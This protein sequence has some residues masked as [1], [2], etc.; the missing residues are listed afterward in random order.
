MAG[1][2]AV[3]AAL[4]EDRATTFAGLVLNER[5]Y[6]RLR[7]TRLREVHVSI[8]V[9]ETFQQRNVGSSVEDGVA[10]ASAIVAT[11]GADGLRATVTLSCAFGCPYEGRV[12]PGAVFELAERLT[13]AGATELVLADTIGV[14]VPSE[15]A[16]LVGRCRRSLSGAVGVHLHDTRATASRASS[17]PSRPVRR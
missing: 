1:A 12:D 15:V 17:P 4:P 8:G 5:G 6:E 2:E 7:A 14:A 10:F 3:V 11:T 13:A 9:T 16:A